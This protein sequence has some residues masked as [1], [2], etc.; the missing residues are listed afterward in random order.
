MTTREY[1]LTAWSWSP[2][3]I[4]A[5]V[6]ALIAYAVAMRRRLTS[7]AGFFVAALAVF[8]LT[9]ASPLN[10]LAEGFLFSAHM[11]QHMLLLL[12]VP[13]LA[14][15]G[16]PATAP[17]TS[18]APSRFRLPPLLGWVAG[19]GAMWI[20]H[21]RT[22]CDLATRTQTFRTIQIISLLIL[23]TLFWWPLL[24]PHA[25]HRIPPL[26][27]VVYLFSACVAC[28]LLGIFVTFSPLGAVC[29][30]YLAPPDRPAILN[31]I[32]ND[33]GFTPG[34]D[35]QIG[36]LL[37]WVPGCGIYLGAVMGLLARWYRD[38]D[39]EDARTSAAPEGASRTIAPYPGGK[40]P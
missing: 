13:L 26:V 7:R 8:F 10:T 9:L 4:G 22:L 17:A 16:L 40:E 36:G 28:S 24:G 35:Q 31:M 1:W 34:K 25:R 21:E 29:P 20:W 15:L 5:T 18:H 19:V 37:M 2:I 12:I 14:L 27:G 23:G 39:S 3:V 38:S 32:R 30:I 11:A 6:V 33:W